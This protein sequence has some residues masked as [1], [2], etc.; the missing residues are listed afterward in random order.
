MKPEFIATCVSVE[1]VNDIE[2]AYA[3]WLADGDPVVKDYLTIQRDIEP[4]EKSVRLGLDKVYVERNDQGF[5]G[6]G[7]V[8][9]AALFRDHLGLRF[10]DKGTTFMGGFSEMRVF[11]KLDSA[12]FQQLRAGLAACFNGFE[13]YRDEA[14]SS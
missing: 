12:V 9:S 5:S 13:G 4:D 8:E 10:N 7:G 2:D 14:S 1:D 11:F 3:V 6:Y